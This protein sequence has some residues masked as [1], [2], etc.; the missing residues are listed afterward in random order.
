MQSAII[1]RQYSDCTNLGEEAQEVANKTFLFRQA[2]LPFSTVCA[3]QFGPVTPEVEKL[4]PQNF[5]KGNPV[6]FINNTSTTSFRLTMSANFSRVS[7]T[8]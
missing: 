6:F 4:I 1:I 7:T 3:V 2:R 8:E 5:R